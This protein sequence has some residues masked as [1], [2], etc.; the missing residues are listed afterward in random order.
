[1]DWKEHFDKDIAYHAATAHEYDAVVVHP[2]EYLNELLF[3]ELREGIVPG[4]TMLDLGCGTGHA[5]LA[6]GSG[7]QSVTGVD[8][9]RDMLRQA[10]R[11]LSARGISNAVLVEADIF[12]F[13]DGLASRVDFVSAIGCLHHL[14]PSTLPGLLGRIHRHMAAGAQLLLADP[15]A[16]DLSAQPAEIEEWNRDS[17]MAN[18]SF[19]SEQEE[20]D[21]APL[22][23]EFLLSSLQDAG[24]GVTYSCRGWEIFPHQL[25]ASIADREKISE[26]HRRFGSTGNVLCLL[27]LKT[28]D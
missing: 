27:C 8:H 21:E 2:R 26:L 5:I 16:V 3:R 7:F 10:R 9:S 22:D 12:G 4:G 20:A 28:G 6:F 15:I 24:F 18:L 14:P 19:S 13:L 17:V 11:N 25:P 23:H 1:M